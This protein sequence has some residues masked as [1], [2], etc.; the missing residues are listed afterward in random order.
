MVPVGKGSRP[1]VDLE[2]YSLINNGIGQL[3]STEELINS[4]TIRTG[5]P[6][7]R[8]SLEGVLKEFNISTEF[9]EVLGAM[10]ATVYGASITAINDF[11]EDEDPLVT[12]RARQYKIAVISYG[13]DVLAAFIPEGQEFNEHELRALALRIEEV[14]LE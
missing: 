7:L 11:S 9:P 10:L 3:V 12:I 13:D 1:G 8:A 5:I 4:Y 2:G 6:V 14:N